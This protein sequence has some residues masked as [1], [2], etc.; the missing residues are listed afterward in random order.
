VTGKGVNM[1][2]VVFNLSPED[3]TVTST[4]VLCIWCLDEKRAK[5][6]EFSVEVG[7]DTNQPCDLCGE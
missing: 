7:E 1:N 3:G 4:Q 2:M 5:D 6:G